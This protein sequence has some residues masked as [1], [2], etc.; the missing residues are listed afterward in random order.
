MMGA[1]DE[2]DNAYSIR[3]ILDL[4]LDLLLIFS[5]RTCH[6]DSVVSLGVDPDNQ[7]LD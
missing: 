3:N 7:A 1:M 2:A 5:I 6:F 4:L